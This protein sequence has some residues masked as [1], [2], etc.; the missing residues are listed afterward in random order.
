MDKET[1]RHTTRVEPMKDIFKV[2]PTK[3]ENKMILKRR[4][5]QQTLIRFII[6]NTEREERG[7]PTGFH[8]I[9]GE[10]HVMLKTEHAGGI[11]AVIPLHS[12][13]QI[14]TDPEDDQEDDER[15]A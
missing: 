6:E 10:D 9:L 14:L 7:K 3:E 15:H 2:E 4:L 1:E 13:E 11:T 12:I 5:N 8:T